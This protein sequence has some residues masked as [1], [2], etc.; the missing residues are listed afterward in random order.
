MI[1]GQRG[2]G[3]SGQGFWRQCVDFKMSVPDPMEG[4]IHFSTLSEN[5]EPK[6]IP[7]KSFMSMSLKYK[8]NEFFKWTVFQLFWIKTK[9]HLDG[10]LV[11]SGKHACL[12][13][14]AIVWPVTAAITDGW[15][16]WNLAW[17]QGTI[18]QFYFLLNSSVTK[19]KTHFSPW[20]SVFLPVK[21]GGWTNE[22]LY[23]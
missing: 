16:Q 21:C 20:V 13:E 5:M 8:T 17:G 22:A 15:G 2:G 4:P 18:L 6:T 3:V 10:Y 7:A 14:V 1:T 11:T 12:W 9:G 23:I 19:T